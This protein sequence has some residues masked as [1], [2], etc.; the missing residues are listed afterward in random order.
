MESDEEKVFSKCQ[1][2]RNSGSVW[3]ERR[4]KKNGGM[5]PAKNVF[6]REMK[7]RSLIGQETPVAAG[8]FCAFFCIK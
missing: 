7:P 1:S 8:Y 4:E 3:H 5:N 2:E 6:K